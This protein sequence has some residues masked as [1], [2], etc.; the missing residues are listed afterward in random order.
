MDTGTPEQIPDRLETPPAAEPLREQFLS[1]HDS[2]KSAKEYL[3]WDLAPVHFKGRPPQWIA[4]KRLLSR[5]HEAV[6]GLSPN[7][8]W[9]PL[10][11][12][13]ITRLENSVKIAFN[14]SRGK[15]SWFKQNTEY[16]GRL[17][18]QTLLDI[19]ERVE[20]QDSA[21]SML[22]ILVFLAI[23]GC[24]PD[25]SCAHTPDTTQALLNASTVW[26]Q[27]VQCP[28]SVPPMSTIGQV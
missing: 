22:K 19:C 11:K 26:L 15:N 17:L 4:I 24:N 6:G 7:A 14:G 27:I 3:A 9:L 18:R 8:H 1:Q 23:P 12:G 28:A 5:L 2:Q 16:G 10:L 20:R 21:L 25:W 13:Q